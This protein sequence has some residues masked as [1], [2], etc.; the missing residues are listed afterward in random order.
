MRFA[1]TIYRLRTEAGLSQNELAEALGVSRQSVSK[2]ETNASVPDL[3]KL[4][5]LAALFHVSLDA[6]VQGEAE[7]AAGHSA[8]PSVPSPAPAPY[9]CT[10]RVGV[11]LICCSIAAGL[12]LCF[13]FGLAGFV[14]VLPP[15]IVGLICRFAKAHPALKA[16]WAGFLMLDLY[17]CLA[18][19]IRASSV[20]LTLHWTQAM[21]PLRLAVSWGLFLLAL[22]LVAGTAVTL[23]KGVWTGS[24]KQKCLLALSLLCLVGASIPIPLAQGASEPYYGLLSLLFLGQSWARLGAVAIL[25]CFLAQFIYARKR[26]PSNQ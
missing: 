4:V 24:V 14:F 15:L 6:L 5:K 16:L 19:G 25:A 23:R 8:A 7:P 22:G 2:W 21:N 13:L 26:R 18:T 17:L 1:E 10:Q 3:D 20:I 12:V 11:G 9:A